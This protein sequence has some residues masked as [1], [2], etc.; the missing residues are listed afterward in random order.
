MFTKKM[1]KKKKETNKTIYSLFVCW[2]KAGSKTVKVR[3]KVE[4]EV[5]VAV[6]AF[7]LGNKTNNYWITHNQLEIFEWIEKKFENISNI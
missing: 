1:K 6:G 5:K 3:V 2:S 7:G 4:V